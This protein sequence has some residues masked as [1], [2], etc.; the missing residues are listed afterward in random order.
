MSAI[1]CAGRR[2]ARAVNEAVETN[3]FV[4]AF[5]DLIS[6]TGEG[7]ALDALRIL[8]AEARLA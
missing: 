3:C 2:L 7:I 6:R 5:V 8:F 4:S 1:A